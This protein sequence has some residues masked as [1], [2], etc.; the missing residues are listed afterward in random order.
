MA[1]LRQRKDVASRPR[2][3][4]RWSSTV[5]STGVEIGTALVHGRDHELVVG[6]MNAGQQFVHRVEHLGDCETRAAQRR[7]RASVH[8]WRSVTKT[9][10]P[11]PAS[12]WT[13]RD[14]GFAGDGGE[15][16][17]D[18]RAHVQRGPESSAG[19]NDAARNLGRLPKICSRRWSVAEVIRA[20]WETTSRSPATHRCSEHDLERLDWAPIRRAAEVALELRAVLIFAE[21]L[22]GLDMRDDRLDRA[23]FGHELTARLRDPEEPKPVGA[24]SDREVHRGC[25]LAGPGGRRPS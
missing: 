6:A 10:R 24:D 16:F 12:S 17:A 22:A 5:C 14:Q 18:L 23:A 19:W 1:P 9:R 4:L 2:R 15:P 21:L 20:A 7:T 11:A 13:S 25:R 3:P 8:G